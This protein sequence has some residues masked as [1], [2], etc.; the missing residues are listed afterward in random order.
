MS[1]TRYERVA[2]AGDEDNSQGK[3][4]SEL[5]REILEER[6]RAQAREGVRNKVEG[7]LRVVASATVLWY[8]DGKK[9][10]FSVIAT[11]ERIPRR[12]LLACGI[13]FGLNFCIFLY[14]TVWLGVVKKK[15]TE[16]E[17]YAEAPLA[18][19][20]GTILGLF[21][22]FS[23][24]ICVWPVYYVLAPVVAFALLLGFIGAMHYVPG[25]A[26]PKEE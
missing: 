13:S 11:D 7:F 4:V 26:E 12:W 14:V 10:L 16:E 17:W 2:S 19:P 24:T 23:F 1:E 18:I 20:A 3:T 25:S 9:D 8:G 15:R 6:K 21:T 22:F 5:E